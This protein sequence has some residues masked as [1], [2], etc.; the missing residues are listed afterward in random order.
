MTI[1]FI[2]D[3]CIILKMKVIYQDIIFFC[4]SVSLFFIFALL[5]INWMS[6]RDLDKNLPA[7][8]L[9][10]KAAKYRRL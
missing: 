1:F 8:K 6:M 4:T 7:E 5:I 10:A 9:R 2:N 3:I